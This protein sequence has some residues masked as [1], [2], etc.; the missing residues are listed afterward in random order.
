[1]ARAS[2]DDI[3][4]EFVQIYCICL[5]KETEEM[6]LCEAE[7]CEVEWFHYDCVGLTRETIPE[8][9]WYCDDCAGN[10]PLAGRKSNTRPQGQGQGQVTQAKQ[11]KKGNLSF[12]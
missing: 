6:I 12:L 10:V 7:N 9:A 2:H 1:M 4:D 3:D 5:G 8:G 11:R